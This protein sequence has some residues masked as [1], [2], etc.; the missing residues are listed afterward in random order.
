MSFGDFFSHLGS[1]VA[2]EAFQTVTPV[3]GQ[4]VQSM[5]TNPTA[6][7][8]PQTAVT[9]AA[10]AVVSLTAVVPNLESTAVSAAAGLISSLWGAIGTAV[11]GGA[12]TSSGVTSA[13]APAAVP[14]AVPQVDPTNNAL[15]ASHM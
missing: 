8:H 7:T 5:Q 11:V 4:I 13:I 9:Q 2:E 3:V 15:T 1:L 10:Q 12:S 6:W 14:A